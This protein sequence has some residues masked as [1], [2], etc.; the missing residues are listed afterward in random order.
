MTGLSWV[1]VLAG[2]W[3]VI[4]PWVLGYTSTAAKVNDVLLGVVIGVVALIIA[5][6]PPPAPQR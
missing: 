1:N 4:A 6:S 5:V 2:I 3:L